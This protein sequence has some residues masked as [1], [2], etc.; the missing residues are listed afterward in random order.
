MLP[1]MARLNDKHTNSDKPYFKA[2]WTIFLPALVVAVLYGSVLL[3]LLAS[4]KGDTDIAKIM[5]LV[6]M[7]VV[8]LLLVRAYLRYASL[9]VQI[10]HDYIAYRQG[11]LRPRWKRLRVDDAA[12]A[13]VRYGAAGSVLGGGDVVLV[14]RVG[15]PVHLLDVAEPEKLAR[16]VRQRIRE[17]G[18]K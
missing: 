14:R 6:L 11:W 16:Q 7:L 5:L 13:T 1:P 10:G 8:P 15:D 3:I 4:G 17:A 9:G 2:H 18:Q 12:G